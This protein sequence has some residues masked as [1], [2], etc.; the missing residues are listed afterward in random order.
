MAITIQI[1][2]ICVLH[3]ASSRRA[4]AAT[5][6]QNDQLYRGPQREESFPTC[7]IIFHG[8]LETLVRPVLKDHM[9]VPERFSTLEHSDSRR[10]LSVSHTPR[11]VDMLADAVLHDR[12][13]MLE[14][15]TTPN[16]SFFVRVSATPP[17][18]GGENLTAEKLAVEERTHD[19]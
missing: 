16:S 8:T 4:P 11:S 1:S 2:P 13:S 14:I 3:S 5:Q 19:A 10:D 6:G 17:K 12:V 7:E 9:S 15:P 18:F